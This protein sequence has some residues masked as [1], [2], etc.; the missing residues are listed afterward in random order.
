M[1]LKYMLDESDPERGYVKRQANDEIVLMVSN[2]GGMSNLELGAL[3]DEL[4]TQLERDYKINPVRIYSGTIESS[5]NA[6]AF[7]TSILNLTASTREGN[8]YSTSQIIEW[9]DVKTSTQWESMQG[10]QST[11]LQGREAQFVKTTKAEDPR[12]VDPSTDVK[13]EPALLEKALRSAAQA[14][15]DREP[16]LTKWD[17]IMGDGDCGETLKTGGVSILQALD[18][19]LAKEGSTVKVLYEL[20]HIVE[21]KMG[22]TLGGIL[23]IFIVSLTTALQKGVKAGEKDVHLWAQA[24]STALSNLQTYTAARKGDRTVMDVFIPLA[25]GLSKGSFKGAVEDV[26]N[27]AE[28]TKKLTPRLGRAT[29]VGVQEGQDLPPDP[30]AWGIMEII[31]GLYAGSV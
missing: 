1:N 12:T 22:G 28:G 30:G 20:E 18:A 6:P 25:E 17:T 5:L 7:S 11:R 31:R 4:L 3:V 15:N 23:G 16:D 24:V 2:F 29:Y 14:V 9:L 10:R 21:S 19:G 13:L 26:V 8:N 27:A